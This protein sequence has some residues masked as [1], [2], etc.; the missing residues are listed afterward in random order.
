[1][2]ELITGTHSIIP[3]HEFH[4]FLFRKDYWLE[5]KDRFL[6]YVDAVVYI[7]GFIKPENDYEF[8]IEDIRK[9]GFNRQ[10]PIDEAVILFKN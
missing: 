10:V 8:I 9:E 1:M 3:L 5:N 2:A 4:T 6:P 7:P